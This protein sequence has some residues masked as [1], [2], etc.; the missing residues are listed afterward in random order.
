[1]HGLASIPAANGGI[2]NASW[3]C[4]PQPLR[5]L[6]GTW[7]LFF[8]TGAI[9]NFILTA[10]S[11]GVVVQVIRG[12]IGRTELLRARSIAQSVAIDTSLPAELLDR[13]TSSAYLLRHFA[14]DYTEAVPSL[15]IPAILG[16]ESA[17]DEPPPR[18]YKVHARFCK[19][20]VV[21]KVMDLTPGASDDGLQWALRR[22]VG[23]RGAAAVDVPLVMPACLLPWA[24]EALGTTRFWNLG[25][26]MH[27]FGRVLG[28]VG[29]PDTLAPESSPLRFLYL[30]RSSWRQRLLLEY[31][32]HPATT[33]LADVVIVAE[34]PSDTSLKYLKPGGLLLGSCAMEKSQIFAAQ[35]GQ[36]LGRVHF[37]QKCFWLLQKSSSGDTRTP[38]SNGIILGGLAKNGIVLPVMK[39]RGSAGADPLK[40][41]IRLGNALF[42]MAA[43]IALAADKGWALQLSLSAV[44]RDY[45]T[46]EDGIWSQLPASYWQIDYADV[47]ALVGSPAGMGYEDPVVPEGARSVMLHGYFQNPRYFAHRLALVRQLLSPSGLRRAASVA[48]SAATRDTLAER[49]CPGACVAIHVRLGDRGPRGLGANFYR[50]AVAVLTRRLR[51]SVPPPTQLPATCVFFSDD[52]AALRAGLADQICERH[53]IFED[54]GLRDDIVLTVMATCCSGIVLSASTFSWWAAVLGNYGAAVVAPRTTKSSCDDATENFTLGAMPGWTRLSVPCF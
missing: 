41:G 32:A 5:S 30:D 24:F 28:I 12:D 8:D 19:Q 4:P 52:P 46:E 37:G 34:Q 51:L 53:I 27:R 10:T 15:T 49:V 26:F 45:F 54:N 29:K 21:M 9:R 3:A 16:H 11:A 33:P 44:W 38:L 18:K 40:A 20:T 31:V 48:W 22:A 25:E 47:D 42:L 17:D 43:A 23:I 14:D 39:T 35:L 50:A 36:L 7:R 2:E 13:S 1:M 6:I